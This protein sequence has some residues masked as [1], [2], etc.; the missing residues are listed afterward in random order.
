MMSVY[1]YLMPTGIGSRPPDNPA[2]EH[3]WK[4]DRWMDGVRSAI[5]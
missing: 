4:M 1:P 5:Q 2:E 3:V